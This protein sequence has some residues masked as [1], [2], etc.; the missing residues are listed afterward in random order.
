MTVVCTTRRE[1]NKYFM[2]VINTQAARFIDSNSI[3][4]VLSFI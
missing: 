3:S 1:A 2:L 4:L